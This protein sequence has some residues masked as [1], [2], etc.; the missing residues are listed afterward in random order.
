MT[1]E[2]LIAINIKNDGMT[3]DATA[4]D[5]TAI[6]AEA[7]LENRANELPWVLSQDISVITRDMRE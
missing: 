5:L 2:Y 3:R 6:L 1:F 4:E 7:V